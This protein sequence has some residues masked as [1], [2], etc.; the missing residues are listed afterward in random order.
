MLVVAAAPMVFAPLIWTFLVTL[1]GQ[2]A[3][4]FAVLS[5]ILL[6]NEAFLGALLVKL[7][8]VTDN[9]SVGR[10]VLLSVH[11]SNTLLMLAALAM[12]A[13]FVK[14]GQPWAGLHRVNGFA[15]VIA[16]LACTLVVGVTGS[17]AALGD[18]LFPASSLQAAFAHEFSPSSPWLLRL[19]VVHPT[20]ALVAAMFVMWLVSRSRRAGSAGLGIVLTGLL[21]VQFALGVADVL[22]LT[23]AW[24][25]ILH[26]L[27]ADLYWIALVALAADISWPTAVAANAPGWRSVVRSDGD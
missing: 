17:M 4:A 25:Q 1:K 13:R 22:L 27:G 23:P 5:T 7:G 3:R 2:G 11:L 20:S 10:M 19:R 18:T 8:Y 12:T 21:A 26:L 24:L 14:T 15:W 16:G 9:Q 6:L